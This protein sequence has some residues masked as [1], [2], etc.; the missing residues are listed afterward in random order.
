LIFDVVVPADLSE[1]KP[2]IRD[3]IEEIAKNIDPTYCCVISFD[4]DYTGR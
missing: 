2:T 3:S 1:T 4:L